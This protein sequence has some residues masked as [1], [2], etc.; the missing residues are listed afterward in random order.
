MDS[1]A[2]DL[3]DFIEIGD[4]YLKK[5]LWKEA[6]EVFARAA[7]REPESNQPPQPAGHFAQERQ[8][9]RRRPGHLPESRSAFPADEGLYFNLARL[10]MDWKK[11][12]NAGQA[13]RKALAIKP[14]FPAAVNL[15]NSVQECLSGGDYQDPAEA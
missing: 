14:D 2:C 11:Y 5:S 15:L 3:D 9:I 1:P 6:Q 8:E 10:F 7:E 12:D 4:S 13:L